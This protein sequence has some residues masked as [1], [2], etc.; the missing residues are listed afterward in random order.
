MNRTKTRL[1]AVGG[2]I[3]AVLGISLT[4]WTLS[5]AATSLPSGN[6]NTSIIVQNVGNAPADFIVDYYLPNGTLLDATDTQFDVTV[7]GTRVFAQAINNDL[8]AGYR[9]VGVVSSDQPINALLVRDILSNAA[10]NNHSY[11]IVNAQ[12]S[13]GNALALPILLDEFSSDQFNSRASVVNTG[14]TTACLK[15]T[16]FV[17]AT[18]SSTPVGQAVVDNPTGQA[19]CASGYSLPAGGQVTFG[20]AGTGTVQFPNATRNTQTAGLIEVLNPS[21]TNQI[22]A[23]VD[24]YRSDGNRLLGSYNG[25][26][27]NNSQPATDDVG[28]DVIVPLAIKHSSGF[29]SVIGVQNIEGTPADVQI[30]YQG[31]TE[32]GT[33]VDVTVTLPQV[34][35]AGFHST[36]DTSTNIPNDFIGYARVTSTKKMAALL[37]RGKQTGY[38]SGINEPIYTAVNGVPADQAASGWNLPLI[39]RR[40]AQT[41]SGS[42]GFNSWIQVQVADGSTAQVTLRFV[43]D[44]NSGC[45]VGPYQQT[46]SVTGSKVFYMN[47]DSDNGFPPGNSPSCF[48]GGAQVTG[49]KPLIVIANVSSDSYPGGDNEGLYNGFKQ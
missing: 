11:S 22:A 30:R 8:G 48:W 31:A 43:G 37:V 1:G 41:F 45:P 13:G 16:Y 23:S 35:N 28:T 27:I 29:Y 12:A 42:I 33:P 34:T 7:G 36:Y 14:T 26:I 46:V 25:F 19:G 39:F 32:S 6:E 44:P 4:A 9:G 24:I 10:S 18:L 47:A 20:R 38:L 15:I 49:T 21:A 2:S 5:Q 40:F 3:A 17:T